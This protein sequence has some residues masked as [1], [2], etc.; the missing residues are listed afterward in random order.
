MIDTGEVRIQL[1]KGG[2]LK[3]ERALGARVTSVR[4]TAWITAERNAGDV[5]IL[6]GDSFI[7]PCDKLVLVGPLSGT[8]TLELQGARDAGS[9]ALTHRRGPI[10]K[11]WALV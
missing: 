5:V 4:G 10:A 9:G 8:V 11:L 3:L 6:P 7:V 1:R 2:H